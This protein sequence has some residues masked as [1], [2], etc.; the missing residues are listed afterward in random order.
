MTWQKIAPLIL[1]SYCLLPSFF[2]VIIALS[3]I[4]GSLGGLNQTS[5][6]KIIA[7]SS[8]NH[9]GWILA[10]ILLIENL[11]EIYFSIYTFLSFS[12]IYIFHSFK[13][14][15]INQA[16][17]LFNNAPLIK[18]CLFINLL[19]LGGLPPFLGFF[20][21]WLIIQSLS[22]NNIIF[23]IF[24]IVCITLIT[25]YY[26]I[27]ISYASFIINYWEISWN[28]KNNFN[29]QII[30]FTYFL[31]FISISGLLLINWLYFIF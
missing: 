26:Y 8:I 25:L 18:F 7:F 10:A 19:S 9:L 4:I 12:I 20:P 24:I 17:S 11:W 1:I 21:K 29:N 27:R 6:R 3:I 5:L 2:T 23:L 14:S 15:H 13:L 22:I 28:F 31:T 30:N 16:F